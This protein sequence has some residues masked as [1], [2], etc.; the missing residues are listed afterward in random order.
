MRIMVHQPEHLPWLGFFN[1]LALVDT[2]VV[3]DNVQYNKRHFQNRN[4]VLTR[5]AVRWVTVPVRQAGRRDQLIRDVEIDCSQDWSARWWNGIRRAYGD[6][7]HGAWV[8]DIASGGDG[9]L[10]MLSTGAAPHG[11]TRKELHDRVL[12]SGVRKGADDPG[13]IPRPPVLVDQTPSLAGLRGL[14]GWCHDHGERDVTSRGCHQTRLRRRTLCRSLTRDRDLREPGSAHAPA[15]ARK[16]AHFHRPHGEAFAHLPRA[17]DVVRRRT[18]PL[19]AGLGT[20]SNHQADSQQHHHPHP[21]PPTRA[22]CAG[23]IPEATA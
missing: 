5:D 4:R 22:T 1:R 3:L 16:R 11:P 7:P 15:E 17:R 18:G 19:H 8:L 13:T 6:H 2:W 23:S 20:S 10:L 21:S 12:K 14:P 9:A